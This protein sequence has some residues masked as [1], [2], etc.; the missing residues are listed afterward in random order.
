MT[1]TFKNKLLLGTAIVAVAGFAAPAFAADLVLDDAT[2]TWADG[3]AGDLG[4]AATG[5]NVNATAD[6]TLTITNDGV[7]DDNGGVN[8][9][10]LGDLTDSTGKTLNIVVTSG[11]DANFTVAIDSVNTAGNFTITG[12]A[13]A[14]ND[15]D[16][17]VTLDDAAVAS[18][19]GG[20][21]VINN[22]AVDGA[23]NDISLT[24]TGGLTVTGTTAVTAG[25]VDGSVAALVVNKA[26]TF[27]GAVTFT[28]GGHANADATGLFQGNTA[29][30]AGATLNDATGQAILTFD[31]VTDATG[32]IV[33]TGNILAAADN[34]GFIVIADDTATTNDTVTFSG[35]LGSATADL[36][37][38]TIGV[39]GADGGHG[40][41]NGT[42]YSTLI[43]IGVADPD[44][45]TVSGDFNGAVTT[46]TMQLLGGDTAAES[47]SATVAANFTGNVQLDDGTAGDGTSTVRFDGTSAQTIT[48]SILA[49]GDDGEGTV[50]I[51]N[52][53]TNSNVSLTGTIAAVGASVDSVQVVSGSTL[54]IVNDIYTQQDA[55]TDIGVDIDGTLVISSADNAVSV[56]DDTGDIDLNG[57]VT[58]TGDNAVDFTT[59][60]DLFIDGTFTSNLDAGIDLTWSSNNNTLIGADSNT[61]INTSNQIIN[62][63]DLFIG[64]N[65]GFTTTLN[66][67]RTAGFNPNVEANAFIVA[68][69]GTVEL[70]SDSKLRVGISSSTVE[71]DEGDDVWI[72]DSDE[73]V[74]LDNVDTNYAT[75]VTNKNIVF[76]TNGLVG[77]TVVTDAI[78]E[79]QDFVADVTFNDASDV[80]ENDHYDGAA[81]ALLNILSANTTNELEDVRQALIA[82]DTTDEAEE[83]A[84]SLSPNVDGGNVVGALT[85]SNISADLVQLASMDAEGS[86]I[87]AGNI[88]NGLRAWIQ[89][90]GQ[91]GQQDDRDGIDGFDID[92]LGFAVGLD[93]QALADQ[94]VIGLAFSYADSEV[95]SDNA[96]NANTEIDTYQISLYG[97]YNVDEATY[98]SGQLGYAFGD[99]ETTREDLGGINNLDAQGD[100]DSN[101]FIARLEAGRAYEVGDMTTLTPHVLANYNYYDADSYRETGAGNAGLNVDQDTLHVFELGAGVDADWMFQQADGSYLKPQVR[102]GF[103]YDLADDEVETTSS[104]IGGGSAFSTEGF[105]PQQ[106]AVDAGVGVTYFSTANWELTANYDYEWKEDYDSHAGFLRAGYKF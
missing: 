31:A 41:F 65:D 64:D 27:T 39:S 106:F 81:D 104:F 103:R 73:S 24:A 19:I 93:T 40:V 84:E 75:L 17:A 97:T 23:N 32:D 21:L 56:D 9:F 6:S 42:V 29:F 66:L 8:V 96:N 70:D 77:L 11:A 82:A 14:G 33:V 57:T 94:M 68:D 48:G 78:D 28:G 71:Y 47:A 58:I 69:G 74:E 63:G 92:T 91:T 3:G 59:A 49:T 80:F 22:A 26:A 60:S 35:N 25:T 89:A 85:V 43:N 5:D 30:T 7:A 12:N 13:D 98:V 34:E 52:T 61:T 99:N 90:F 95:D 4:A 72:I 37:T 86:G 79:S 101:Q 18:M 83:I 20:N 36:N 10:S 46:T 16:I 76:L 100:F 87:A 45:D 2:E 105:D 51:G 54:R 15:G 53:G 55:G 102:L 44:G 62:A 88:T 1:N 38:I 50:I 67:T